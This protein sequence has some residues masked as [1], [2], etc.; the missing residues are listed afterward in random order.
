M[1]QLALALVVLLIGG[2]LANCS[3][4]QQNTPAP[5]TTPVVVTPSPTPTASPTVA[6]SPTPTPTATAMPT[7]RSTPPPT[8][9][10][11]PTSTPNPMIPIMEGKWEKIDFPGTRVDAILIYP[12][13]GSLQIIQLPWQGERGQVWV[14]R[15]G[16]SLTYVGEK[17]TI[18]EAVQRNRVGEQR[19]YFHERIIPHLEMN[20]GFLPPVNGKLRASLEVIV[21][22]DNILFATILDLSSNV[23]SVFPTREARRIV[24]SADNGNSWVEIAP[25]RILRIEYDP[26]LAIGRECL[27]LANEGELWRLPWQISSP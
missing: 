15:D 21:Q 9:T 13:D 6:P 27:Y 10:P 24:V 22:E 4:P 19:S 14:T 8:S 5:K 23:G 25:P 12:N 3:S 1:R 26:S 16:N 11:G 20:P 17:T 18:S 2:A 7:S